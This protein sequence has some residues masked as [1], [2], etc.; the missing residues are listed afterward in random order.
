MYGRRECPKETSDVFSVCDEFLPPMGKSECGGSCCS[1]PGEYPVSK[2]G[3]PFGGDWLAEGQ[4]EIP[5]GFGDPPLGAGRV[6]PSEHVVEVDG[7][8]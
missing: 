6:T 8:T 1:S 7:S 5:D 2:G 4:M 3:D